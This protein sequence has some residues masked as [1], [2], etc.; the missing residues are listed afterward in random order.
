[1]DSP[2][3]PQGLA[4]DGTINPGRNQVIW[5]DGYGRVA[6]GQQGTSVIAGHASWEGAPDAFS[7][8][9]GVSIGDL[10][11]VGY[12]DGTSRPFTVTRT[13]T[14]GKHDL[15][16]STLVW[17][18]HPGVARLA[19]ITCDDDLGYLPDGHTAGNY[20]VIAEG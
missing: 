1:M 14:V 4:A 2:I 13:E 11:E 9:P 19:I 16:R 10:V 18:D 5:F 12:G 6:P 3:G 15:A 17:G 20:V 8:L 7:G